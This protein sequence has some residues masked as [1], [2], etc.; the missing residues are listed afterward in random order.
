MN[1]KKLWAILLV[2]LSASASLCAT[3]FVSFSGVYEKSG[4]HFDTSS[5]SSFYLDGN[6]NILGGSVSLKFLTEKGFG[7]YFDMFLGCVADEDSIQVETSFPVLRNE[8]RGGLVYRK[9]FDEVGIALNIAGFFGNVFNYNKG[10]YYGRPE[11]I[12]TS[13]ENIVT[14]GAELSFDCKISNDGYLSFGSRLDNAFVAYG[15]TEISKPTSKLKKELEKAE[16][17]GT[18]VSIFVGYTRKCK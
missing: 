6:E 17:Y 14:Y 12:V 8:S 13:F 7:L 10:S 18:A 2:V 5:T 4:Q 16:T 3:T 1:A 11:W 15:T 9:E